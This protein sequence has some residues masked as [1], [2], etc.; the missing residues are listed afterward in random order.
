MLPLLLLP[1]HPVAFFL[2][3]QNN[4]YFN[5]PKRVHSL[6]KA[7]KQWKRP[8]ILFESVLPT[9]FNIFRPEWPKI[10]AAE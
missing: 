10:S 7:E 1:V 9:L 3:F 6:L 2:K 5:F 8:D 4:D